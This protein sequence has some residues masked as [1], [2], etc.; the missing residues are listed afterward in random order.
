LGNLRELLRQRCE[1]WQK[2][3]EMRAHLNT[4]RQPCSKSLKDTRVILVAHRLRH[5]QVACQLVCCETLNYWKTL[6][7]WTHSVVEDSSKA[8]FTITLT[9]G[10]GDGVGLDADW[11]DGKTL[12]IVRIKEGLVSKWNSDNQDNQIKLGDSIVEINASRGDSKAL[13]AIVK[14][15]TTLKMSIIRSQAHA[16]A[17]LRPFD[18]S[19]EQ[20]L[21][22]YGLTS[23]LDAREKATPA[24]ACALWSLASSL[25]ALNAFVRKAAAAMPPESLDR[26]GM[27]ATRQLMCLSDRGQKKAVPSEEPRTQVEDMAWSRYGHVVIL[28]A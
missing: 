22:A 6:G 3:E 18:T 25:W 2:N 13:L 15:A 5:L 12:T 28:H 21:H 9:K 11:A 17:G 8:E 19:P 23:K 7:Q 4:L 27:Q 14:E 24:G 16:R 26:P 1:G 20:L 10:I